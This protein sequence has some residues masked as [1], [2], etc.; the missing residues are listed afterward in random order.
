MLSVRGI[1][2]K[3]KD[4]QALSHVSFDVESGSI[5]GLIGHNG[6]GKTTLIRV[7]TQILKADT[8]EI[9][10]NNEKLKS[11][12]KYLVGYLPEER[13]VY[14]KMTVFGYLM[15]LARL[16]DLLKKDATIKIN[17]WLQKLRLDHVAQKEIS[18][19]SKGMQQKVQFIATVFFEPK[20]LILDEPFSGFDP[21]NTE[22]LKQEILE[23][24]A[25]GVTVIFSTHQMEA[26]EELCEKVTMI[27]NSQVV[28]SGD[29]AKI[30]SQYRKDELYLEGSDTLN[31]SQEWN[32]VSYKK[33]YKI[34]LAPGQSK[35]N[36]LNELDL[37]SVSL[38]QELHPSLKQIFLSKV[39]EL[40]NQV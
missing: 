10:I 18:C 21:A 36:L 4:H 35:S 1:S 30:K 38:I 34:T 31:L 15:F 16:H 27:S 37:N 11:S 25:K 19:L 6:A 39:K 3:F 24:N 29:L 8:G 2:K 5:Y 17:Y 22:L 40:E 28:L 13:G 26:V 33:G 14:K 9:Y 32:C 7:I 23:L 20:L 12:H